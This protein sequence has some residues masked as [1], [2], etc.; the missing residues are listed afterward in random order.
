LKGSTHFPAK[1]MIKG[2]EKLNSLA[3]NIP[4]IRVLAP[5]E[6]EIH[7]NQPTKEFIYYLS[8][9]DCGVLH[10]SLAKKDLLFAEDWNVTSGAYTLNHRTLTENKKY[11]RKIQKAI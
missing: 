2:A 10:P 3:D 4:G 1:K 7:L 6:I 8:L 9:A 11:H 5:R